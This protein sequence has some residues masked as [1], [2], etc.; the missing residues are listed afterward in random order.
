LVNEEGDVRTRTVLF[1]LGAGLI[2]LAGCAG[3]GEVVTLDLRTIPPATEAIAKTPDGLRVAVAAFEDA[4]PET[5]RLGTRT[6]LWGGE[7]Y[8]DLTGGKPA[9]V[10]PLVIA[11]YLKQK[12]WRA[13]VVKSG[14]ASGA[15]SPDVLLTGKLLDFSVNAKSRVFSTKI[16][17]TTKMAVQAKN[18]ADGSVVRMTLNGEGSQGVF[19]F[20]P[21]DAQNLINDILTDSLE[22]LL[23]TTKVENNL[24]RLK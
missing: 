5:K 14:D 6:H 12:G 22:K 18:T 2:A 9:D 21:E 11:E 3:K 15:G 1:A 23:T 10:V 20:E 19:S 24:L 7:T 17:A 4:R 8:F 16:T 13:E